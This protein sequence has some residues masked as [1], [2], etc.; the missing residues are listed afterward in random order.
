MQR[1][2]FFCMAFFAA[3]IVFPADLEL[4]APN[5]GENL[6]R[7]RIQMITW[8]AQGVQGNVRLILLREGERLGIIADS[9]AASAGSFSWTVGSYKRG[10]TLETAAIGGGYKIRVKAVQG[11]AEDASDRPFS[12][13]D[14]HPVRD[15]KTL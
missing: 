12:I 11:T 14:P 6:V 2:C 7:G 4:S 9:I 13:A 5:G 3:S 15:A 1:V 8:R 10:A